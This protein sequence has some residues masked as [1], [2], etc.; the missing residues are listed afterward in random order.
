MTV[1]RIKRNRRGTFDVKL[2]DEEIRV[3]LS[4]APQL[5]TL[6]THGADD[7]DLRRLF[8]S[9]YTDDAD[10]DAFYRL[11]A[12]DSL[13]DKRLANLDLLEAV[14]AEKEWTAGQLEA[15]MG[16]VNDLRL[17]LGTKLDVS[18]NDDP[19]EL[20][21]EDPNAPAFALYSYLGWLLELVVEA[22]FSTIPEAGTDPDQA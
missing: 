7:G 8:P 17:V 18:E 20:S 11:L 16:A 4:L 22:L 19:G 13:L 21:D 10:A 9:A 15:V 3:L 12:H 5:R 6:L 2:P 1:R 14:I